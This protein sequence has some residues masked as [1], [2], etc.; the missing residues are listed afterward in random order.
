MKHFT[1]ASV[2]AGCDKVFRGLDE[3]GI[4]DRASEHAANEHGVTVDDARGPI[5]ANIS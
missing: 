1:C 4:A 2:F 5:L 3:G